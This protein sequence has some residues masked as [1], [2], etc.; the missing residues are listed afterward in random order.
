MYGPWFGM[1]RHFRPCF[2]HS[3]TCFGQFRRCFGLLRHALA[4]FRYFSTC[5]A[6]L[7]PFSEFLGHLRQFS[8]S[9]AMLRFFLD[10]CWAIFRHFLTCSAMF[11][12]FL[13]HF[14]ACS[15]GLGHA[16]V[17]SRHRLANFSALFRPFCGISRH[18][19]P[20]FG[21]VRH[22]PA[23]FGMSRQVRLW[24]G[25][26]STC[27]V[28][29]RPWFGNFVTIL[30]HFDPRCTF[31]GHVDHLWPLFECM[32][33]AEVGAHLVHHKVMC[34]RHRRRRRG[35]GLRPRPG[36]VAHRKT[37]DRSIAH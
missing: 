10:M 13:W 33:E 3:S 32:R 8:T 25:H 14:G 28:I 7:R 21:H 1:S 5:S 29:F 24:L 27:S 11:R 2:G 19:R 34:R 23:I 35:R 20:C 36:I 18:V 16:A 17:F 22:F 9:S 30:D 12:P 15:A 6:M 31:F 26:F 37:D 4:M